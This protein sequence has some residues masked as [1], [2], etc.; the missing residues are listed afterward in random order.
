M[1]I[2]TNNDRKYNFKKKTYSFE[3]NG[4]KV[5]E[6]KQVYLAI[7]YRERVS[8][9]TVPSTIWPIFSEFFI[10]YQLIL[11]AFR[12][13]NMRNEENIGHIVRGGN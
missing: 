7:S 10:F 3:I 2:K 6:Y 13:V 5:R 11:Q 12:W 9:R 4:K 8:Y 1:Q